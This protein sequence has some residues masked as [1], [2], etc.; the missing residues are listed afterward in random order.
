MHAKIY[1]F[2]PWTETNT[3]VLDIDDYNKVQK[4]VL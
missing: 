4:T 3:P 1:A 2:T